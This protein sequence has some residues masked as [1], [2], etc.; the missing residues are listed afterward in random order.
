MTIACADST[1]IVLCYGYVFPSFG[2]W[3]VGQGCADIIKQMYTPWLFDIVAMH[4]VGL[5]AQSRHRVYRMLRS[6]MLRWHRDDTIRSYNQGRQYEAL[7]GKDNH[8]C[9]FE[10]K[11]KPE[12]HSVRIYIVALITH[13]VLSQIPSPYHTYPA[14]DRVT[15]QWLCRHD[16]I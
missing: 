12:V 11:F 6:R 1:C 14:C 13:T 4:F 16:F 9:G 15:S 8:W 10:N 7:D 3:L 2:A 5:P